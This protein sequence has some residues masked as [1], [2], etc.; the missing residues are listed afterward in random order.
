MQSSENPEI[1]VMSSAAT[2]NLLR[3]ARGAQRLVLCYKIASDYQSQLNQLVMHKA[4]L[5]T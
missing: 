5:M 2:G 1:R 3:S 4:A